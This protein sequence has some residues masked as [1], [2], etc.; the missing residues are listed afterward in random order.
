MKRGSKKEKEVL[1]YT[2]HSSW[3]VDGKVG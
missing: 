1:K 2:K 3:L